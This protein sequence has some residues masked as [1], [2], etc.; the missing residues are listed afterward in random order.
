MNQN[1]LVLMDTSELIHRMFSIC[2]R[3]YN[4]EPAFITGMIDYIGS[5]SFLLLP[6][7]DY[8]IIFLL[9]SIEPYWRFDFCP[10]YKGKRS[11]PS[12]AYLSFRSLVLEYIQENFSY[13]YEGTFEADD[14]AGAIVRLVEGTEI[15]LFASDSDWQ[16]LVSDRVTMISHYL[17]AV[18]N[19]LTVW[20]WLVRKRE[21]QGKK[22]KSLWILPSFEDFKCRDIWGW[23]AATGDRSDNLSPGCP[24]GLISLLE[25]IIDVLKVEGFEERVRTVIKYTAIVKPSRK[26]TLSFLS[27]LVDVPIK[28]L[29]LCDF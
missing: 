21:K 12:D 20:L 27:D 26:V 5:G 7:R 16:G 14:L 17:P 1:T 8:K 15:F 28:I 19:P 10:E 29:N 2:E 9:D 4:F 6:N 22:M 11:P 23:K 18:R 25:P 3:Y 24:L 13:I